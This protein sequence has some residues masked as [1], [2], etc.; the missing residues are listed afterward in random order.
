MISDDLPDAGDGDDPAIGVGMGGSCPE[1]RAPVDLGQ[2][3]CLECGAPIRYTS[4]QRRRGRSG[5][6]QATNVATRA[7][8]RP[9]GFPW[10]PFLIVLALV[11]GGVAFAL[12]DGND[13]K[14]KGSSDAKTEAAL[15]SI[16]TGTPT[17]TS[18]S[19]TVTLQDCDPSQPLGDTQPAESSE[20]DA[21]GTATDGTET[22][23]T[24]TPNDLGGDTADSSDPFGDTSTDASSD[25]AT[26]TTQTVDQN[27]APCTS[28]TTT[29]TSTDTTTTATT[30]STDTS[31]S[32]TT[33]STTSTTAGAWPSGKTGWTVIV[34]GYPAQ[35]RANQSAADLQAKNIES[36]VLFSSDYG[37]LCPGIWV[38]FSG[39]FDTKAQ[40][41]THLDEL[42]EKGY[43]GMYARK[44]A[45]GGT[46]TGCR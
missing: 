14:G 25:A 18:T 39:V 10:V 11:I 9:R 4:K 7:P 42:V 36:G 43:G 40:A 3:F 37:S 5:T 1:C 13:S 8:A 27:G 24:M 16:S 2:E 46:P 45:T 12:V 33:A 28:D 34:F 26:G 31:T 23:P 32:T 44:I 20:F 19:D 6:G 21:T 30:T 22:I 29:D 41:D 38:V 15:P 17:T 35:A